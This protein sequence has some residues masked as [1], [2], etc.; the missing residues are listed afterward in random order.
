VAA[1]VELDAQAAATASSSWLSQLTRAASSA[2]DG[3]MGPS[4][5]S[6]NGHGSGS[7]T[8]PGAAGSDGV[9]KA[10]RGREAAA[11]AEQPPAKRAQQDHIILVLG[12]LHAAVAALRWC[13]PLALGC[14]LATAS[15]STLLLP[16]NQPTNH[17][18]AGWSAGPHAGQP[19]HALLQPPPQHGAVGACQRSVKLRRRHGDT[20]CLA[21]GRM[22]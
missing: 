4:S 17:R 19:Q 15:V 9:V 18:C 14:A 16:T 3:L 2:A 10:P 13:L 5:S 20:T 1:C 21:H 12:E 8:R 22:R 6:S 11:A 7:G